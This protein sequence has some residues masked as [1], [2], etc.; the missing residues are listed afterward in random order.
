MA[1]EEDREEGTSGDDEE[2]LT[3]REFV[4]E[5]G[6]DVI[7]AVAIVGIAIGSIFAY[8]GV[9]P[10]M[11]VVESGSMQHSSSASYLGVID[12]G[13]LVLVQAVDSDPGLVTTYVQGRA[14]GYD[15]YSNYGDVI[16]FHPPGAPPSVTP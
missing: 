10:P 2:T 1:P 12:T 7:L 9:W 5:L 3:A 16:V 11:V 13:D 8:S 4:I 14:T 15:T 6:R